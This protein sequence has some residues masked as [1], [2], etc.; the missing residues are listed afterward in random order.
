M[1]QGSFLLFCC[2]YCYGF[3]CCFFRWMN[4]RENIGTFLVYFLG[5][6]FVYSILRGQCR[7]WQ[8]SFFYL[9]RFYLEY[10]RPYEGEI[11]VVWLFLSKIFW[12]SFYS[13]LHRRVIEHRAVEKHSTP[14]FTC[15]FTGCRVGFLHCRWMMVECVCVC[16]TVGIYSEA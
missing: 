10:V 3:C 2:K 1:F 16:V 13:D 15:A 8:Q 9:R 6:Y 12:F 4:R 7:A 11:N 14:C 5:K